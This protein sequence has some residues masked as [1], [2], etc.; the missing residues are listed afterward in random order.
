M[1]SR[2]GTSMPART[3]G[4]AESL[5][6]ESTRT[7]LEPVISLENEPSCVPGVAARMEAHAD[8]VR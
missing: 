5:P 7:A 8:D 4:P 1:R 6:C 3:Y 2:S